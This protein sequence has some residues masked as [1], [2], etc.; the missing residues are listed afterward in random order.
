MKIHKCYFCNFERRNLTYLKQ[1][2]EY[3]VSKYEDVEF[4]SSDELVKLIKDEKRK[5]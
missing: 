5:Y 2:L 3:I 1:L 4:M